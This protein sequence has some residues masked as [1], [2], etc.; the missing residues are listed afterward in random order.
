MKQVGTSTV[1]SPRLDEEYS[2]RDLRQTRFAPLNW[3]V[4]GLIVEG[5]TILAARPKL[6]KSWM[7]LDIAIAAASGGKALT[8]IPCDKMVALY[9][10]LED[11]PRRLKRR[12]R[13]LVGQ[14]V[15]AR[16]LYIRHKLDRLDRGGLDDIRDWV[17]ERGAD[18]VIIDTYNHIRPPRKGNEE[19]YSADYACLSKLQALAAELHIAIVIVHHVRKA[20]AVD[21][22]D[23]ITGSTGLQ[24]AADTLLVMARD[25]EGVVL[26]GRGRDLEEEIEKAM[27]FDRET[28]RWRILGEA[29]DVRRSPERKAI[30]DALRRVGKPIGPNDIAEAV[31]RPYGSVRKMLMIMSKAGE[32]NKTARGLYAA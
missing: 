12:A 29:G 3:V 15:W 13:R 20:E 27:S 14:D 2:F 19:P 28:C 17:E 5:L 9:Y 16:D 6:C 21:P 22:M 4:D 32:V 1:K 18:L 30:I 11:N 23:M 10:A 26:N 24:A 7:V 31:G 8:D 25:S